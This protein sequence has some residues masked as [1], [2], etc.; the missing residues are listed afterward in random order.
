MLDFGVGFWKQ[1]VVLCHGVTD[2]RKGA[3]I[4]LL[5]LL[6]FVEVVV[7]SMVDS[8]FGIVSNFNLYATFGSIAADLRM[9]ITSMNT[10][11]T[12]SYIGQFVLNVKLFLLRTRFRSS[13]WLAL[14]RFS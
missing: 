5:A 13:S 8:G 11:A 6:E 9:V 2:L 3:I 14:L 1:E 10:S 12:E 7:K 4:G